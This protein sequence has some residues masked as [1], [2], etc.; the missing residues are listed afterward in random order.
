MISPEQCRAARAWVGWSQEELASAARVSL[1]TV[2]DFERGDREPIAHNIEAIERA[3][4][5]AGILFSSGAG[6]LAGINYDP[7]IKERDTYV[8]ILEL[9]AASPDG[10]CKTSEIISELERRFAPTGGYA[11]VLANRS[12]TR[13]SQIVR[14]VVSHRDSPSNLIGAGLAVYDKVRRGLRITPEGRA[15]LGL[16]EAQQRIL[17]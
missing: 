1:S 5:D 6:Q 12:D 10:F 17:L 7:R 13:F 2:R 8:P 14:N 15:H 9:L 3:L 4:Y 11:E 16:P